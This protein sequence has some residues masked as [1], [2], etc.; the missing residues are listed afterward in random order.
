ML[1]PLLEFYSEPPHDVAKPVIRRLNQL[2]KPPTGAGRL[3]GL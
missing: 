1:D 3:G 2:K